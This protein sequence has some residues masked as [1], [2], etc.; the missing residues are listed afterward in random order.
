MLTESDIRLSSS[1][2]GLEPYSVSRARRPSFISANRATHALYSVFLQHSTNMHE[3][4]V[5]RRLDRHESIKVVL[6]EH[7]DSFGPRVDRPLQVVDTNR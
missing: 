4:T 7:L 5:S 2:S 3:L 6:H 1:W